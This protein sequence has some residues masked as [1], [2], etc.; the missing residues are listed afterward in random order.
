[1]ST[2]FITFG[3]VACV[4]IFDY[5]CYKQR[6]WTIKNRHDVLKEEFGKTKKYQRLYY[7]LLGKHQTLQQ[8][9][10]ELRREHEALQL[11]E[12]KAH[13]RL[14]GL[15]KAFER[16]NIIDFVEEVSSLVDGYT[17]FKTVSKGTCGA[18]SLKITTDEETGEVDE[19]IRTTLRRDA[20]HKL[21]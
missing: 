7:N 18:H 10:H 21:L 4:L 15:H 12:L 11:T 8:E 19:S 9:H 14:V 17:E 20:E 16:S 3:I 6:I 2:F 5:A 1:M 13:N